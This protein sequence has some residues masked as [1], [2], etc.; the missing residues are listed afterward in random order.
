[1]RPSGKMTS[2]LLLDLLDQRAGGERARRI[3][4]ARVRHAQERLDPPALR[5]AVVD[6]EDRRGVEQREDERRVEERDVVERDDA[7]LSRRRQVFEPDDFEPERDPPQD[8]RTNGVVGRQAAEEID[9]GEEI[10]DSEAGER[11]RLVDAGQLQDQRRQRSS[12]RP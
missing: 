12:R 6:G 11:G 9:R 3:E 7:A 5:D 1:M 8:R 2:R 4:R 10:G